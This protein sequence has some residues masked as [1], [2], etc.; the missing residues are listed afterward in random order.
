MA[1]RMEYSEEKKMILAEMEGPFDL[2]VVRKMATMQARLVREH[3]CYRFLNDSRK[4]EIN[5][6]I[7]D[8]CKVPK[9]VNEEGVP[10]SCMCA[11]VVGTLRDEYRFME[12]IATNHGMIMR[13][14]LE[15]DEA[16]EWLRAGTG[17]GRGGK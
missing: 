6:S 17:E 10:G 3:N 1:F 4:A 2:P 13:I 11:I 12:T 9:I 14:F 16:A 7:A 5:T 15:M 8:I